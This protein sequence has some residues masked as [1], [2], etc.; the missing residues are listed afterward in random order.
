MKKTTPQQL[1]TVI[2]LSPT[3]FIKDI[4]KATGLS[5]QM[6]RRIQMDPEHGITNP[7]RVKNDQAVLEQIKPG[8][9]TSALVRA[10]GMSKQLVNYYKKRGTKPPARAEVFDIDKYAKK[11]A[12]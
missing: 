5:K 3:H 11:Y 7:R 12:I 2:E 8:V 10:T 1:A 9:P 4:V 6:V